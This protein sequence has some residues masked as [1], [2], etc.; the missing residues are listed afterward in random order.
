M[1]VANSEVIV[2]KLP[3]CDIPKCENTALYDG[4]TTFGPW[5]YMCQAHF[6]ALGV[7]LGLGRGQKL[8]VKG[9]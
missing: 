2:H 9:K 4:A 1:T 8:V 3:P 5:A 7:G 6:D